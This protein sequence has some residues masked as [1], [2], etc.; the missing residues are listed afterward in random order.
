MHRRD[1][2][3]RPLEERNMSEATSTNTAFETVIDNR[4]RC[5][6][7]GIRVGLQRCHIIRD[8]DRHSW[9]DLKLRHWLPLQVRD[10]LWH[11]PG[12][13]L[14]MCRDH[15]SCFDNYTFFIR[16]FP[17]EQKFVFVNYSDKQSS[18]V[19]WQGYYRP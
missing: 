2:M 6:V 15:Q 17:D 7:C 9:Y 5:V 13:G 4:D 10:N 18:T 8:G 12:N 14:L 11:E 16:F 1:K 3:S 19:P